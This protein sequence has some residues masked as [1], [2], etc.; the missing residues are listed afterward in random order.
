[1]QPLFSPHPCKGLQ[2]N[3]QLL[4]SLIEVG[5]PFCFPSRAIWSL[6]VLPE[7]IFY[8]FAFLSFICSLGNVSGEDNS[9]ISNMRGG[10]YGSSPSELCLSPV[11][12]PASWCWPGKQALHSRAVA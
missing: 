9:L 7:L 11:S 12:R 4:L 2:T 10:F 6:T 1:M 8:F 5:K 3:H